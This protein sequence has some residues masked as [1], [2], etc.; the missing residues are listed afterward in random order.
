MRNFNLHI[1]ADERNRQAMLKQMLVRVGAS[2]PPPVASKQQSQF[3]ERFQLKNRIAQYR[4]AIRLRRG[5]AETN[6]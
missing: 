5:F 2:Y 6:D 1:P 3:N 4:A